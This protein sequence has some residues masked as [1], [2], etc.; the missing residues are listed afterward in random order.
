MK[1]TIHI[2]R[3]KIGPNQPVLIIA[4]AGVNHFGRLDRAL[5]LV[6]IAVDAGAD[7][8]KTQVYKTENMISA[9]ATKWRARMKAKEMSYKDME[10]VFNYCNKRNIQFLA[11]AHDIESV[12][13]L[14]SLGVDAFK[15]GSGEKD[16]HDY[17]KYV[18]MKGKPV[19]LSTGMH[20]LAEVKR[21]IEVLKSADCK[22]I[23]I[24]HCTTLYPTKPSEVNL[25]AMDILK[26]NFTG[27]VGYSDHTIGIR[28]V[29]AAVARDAC[30]IEKHIALEKEYPNTWDPIVS[31]NATELKEMIEAI[32]S[33]EQ[34][35]GAPEKK[36]SHRE[37]GSIKWAR[38]SIVARIAIPRGAVLTKRM[39]N[40]KRPGTGM[41][42][43]KIGKVLG[44]RIKKD[45]EK[46]T[47]ITSD[48]LE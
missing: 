44:R 11:S 47:L 2:R 26:A 36:P 5:K 41:T 29:L 24:L 18:G 43:S 35:L 23:A 13:F 1:E 46:E 45:I 27:P 4:E 33:I 22:E 32:R 34:L 21:A 17:L 8:F 19:I 31:C 25:K 30:I 37:Q 9:K 39:L 20:S 14:E 3:R 28:A 38:K 48:L 12:N 10:K 6:D 15:I 40:V 7:V 16:N 42:P